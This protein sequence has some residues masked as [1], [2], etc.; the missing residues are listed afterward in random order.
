L[1]ATTAASG[2]GWRRHRQP[3]CL[4]IIETISVA[5]SPVGVDVT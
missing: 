5:L 2:A 1:D 4:I 3:A